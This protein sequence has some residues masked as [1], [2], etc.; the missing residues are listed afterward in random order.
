MREHNARALDLSAPHTPAERRIAERAGAVTREDIDALI[1][2]P[3]DAPEGS[4]PA[5]ADGGEE[6]SETPV[7]A[8]SSHPQDTEDLI[9]M[10]L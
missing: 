9:D 3:A 1:S 10:I 6:L 4:R 5:P 7:A 2:S 8:D